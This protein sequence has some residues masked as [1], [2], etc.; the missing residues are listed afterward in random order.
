MKL[1]GIKIRVSLQNLKQFEEA[2]LNHN[3]VIK[4]NQ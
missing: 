3:K 2:I 4:L 1:F